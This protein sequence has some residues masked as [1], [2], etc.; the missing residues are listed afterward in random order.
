[1]GVKYAE[2]GAERYVTGKIEP[3]DQKNEMFCRSVW[4]PKVADIGEKFYMEETPPKN[5][6]GHRLF[7]QSLVNGAWHLENYY[8]AGCAGGRKGLY[9][10]DRTG[11]Y[12]YPNVPPGLKISVDN[13]KEVTSLIKKTASFYGASLVGICKLDRRWL[14]SSAYFLDPKGGKVAENNLPE[15]LTNAIVMAVEMDYGSI[16]HSPSCIASGAVGLGYSKMAFTSGLLAEYIRGLGYQAIACGN[17]TACSVPLAIDAGLG[18]IA[19]N[20]ILITPEFGPRVRL[21]KVLTDLPL[22][23]DRPIEFG[24]WDFCRICEKCAKHCP[25]QAIVY[26][27]PSDKIN[28]IS[29]REGVLTW[30]IDAE[31]CLSFW[32][33]NGN[34][35]GNCIRTCPFN[36]PDG[37][38]HDF[39]RWGIRTTPGLNRLFLWGDDIMGYGKE[40]KADSFWGQA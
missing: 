11:K 24:V 26:G 8:A 32:A 40:R 35:C 10:W 21:A 12:V 38:L 1:M 36:K 29:N 17:D 25:S 39:V 28:N 23:L 34:D 16:M 19:R 4:D 30:H 9:S 20:G 14:Y 33:T 31:K 5:Q 15:E 18:E 22:I 2:K 37:R 13:E 3:F 27:E 6:P 7:E